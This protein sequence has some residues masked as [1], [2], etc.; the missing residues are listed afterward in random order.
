VRLFRRRP[1]LHQGI[2]EDDVQVLVG[3]PAEPPSDAK[4]AEVREIAGSHPT[5]R[6]VY[7]TQRLVAASDEE[8]TILLGLVLDDAA[9]YAAIAQEI[10]DR[11]YPIRPGDS[12]LDFERL[13]DEPDDDSWLRV[14]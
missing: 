10:G 4:L 6:A 5:L 12:S 14:Y 11:V 3:R 7:L 8:P 9:D 13:D 1:H 2:V